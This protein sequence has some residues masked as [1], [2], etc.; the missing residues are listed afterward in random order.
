MPAII[1]LNDPEQKFRREPLSPTNL[2]LKNIGVEKKNSNSLNWELITQSAEWQPRDSA[3]S[4]IFQDKIWTMGGLNGNGNIGLD[5]YIR[6][7]EA[8]HFNDIWSSTDGANWKLE[9]ENAEWAKRRSMSVVFFQ[10]KLW[11]FGG[12]SPVTGYTSDVWQSTDG[13]NWIEVLTNAP[14]EPRE[15]QT[16]EVFQGKIWIIGGV[17]Y[18]KRETK[19]DVWWS[20]NGID[21]HEG[22]S[23]APWSSRWDHATAVFNG[24]IFLSGG[25]DLNGN[26]FKDVW[27]SPD[28][29]NWEMEEANPLWQERQ[30]HSMVSLNNKLWII[31]R[32]TDKGGSG[33][34]DI[35]FTENG[36][37]WQKT[38]T[39]PPWIG[40]EDHSVLVFKNKIF[41]FGG[42]DSNWQWRN[43]VW[44]AYIAD[45]SL[46]QLTADSFISVFVSKDGQE[47]IL[48]E[49][50]TDIRLPIAS[51]TKMMTAIVATEKYGTR[52]I[53][54]LSPNS[55]RV[56]GSSGT[57]KPETKIV[58]PD[59]L[60]AM[61][62][63][64][65]N[66]IAAALAGE[67][68]EKSFVESMNDKAKDLGLLN[69]HFVNSIGT[70]PDYYDSQINLSTAFD[71]YKLTKY[72]EENKP[73]LLAITKLQ[74][75][76]ILDADGNFIS[77]IKNTDQ[78]LLRGDLPFSI[79]GGKTGETPKAKKN[80]S[81]VTNAPC[82][83][84]IYSVVLGS[85]D[86]FM[87]ME[88]LLRYINN[89]YTWNCLPE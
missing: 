60:K 3:A 63:A 86:N 6:Y 4:F 34:N 62:I 47:K 41:V 78:L 38:D 33:A 11:M 15:G 61:L 39:D 75:Y 42:M 18:D 14:W 23:K 9:K 73:E 46:P 31:G 48:A 21:W 87:D 65:H 49:K 25:M 44:S 30:G 5:H 20:D 54:T 74:E 53:V 1:S 76:E 64:S 58:F 52:D 68:G 88:R 43:D 50:D 16:T 36:K 10:D 56:K 71:V 83:G 84:K 37:D 79:I 24:K 51:I 77:K 28:G 81:L 66:E 69:T 32:L 2:P 27:S 57:Y 45:D 7:W 67:T 19:N 40:R 13:I 72:I 59:A 89:S 35:W 22:I 82:E 85:E 26:V 80:L 17:N 55:T 12:W 29:V 70:D 8:P